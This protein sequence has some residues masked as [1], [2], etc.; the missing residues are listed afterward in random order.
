MNY[1]KYFEKTGK[2]FGVSS[3][4][5]FGRWYHDVKAFDNLEEAEEWLHTET[6][7]FA[8]RELMSRSRAIKYTSK[9]EVNYAVTRIGYFIK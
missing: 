4:Y 5:N 9:K 7:C 2:I 8:E 6:Y 1:E 3:V